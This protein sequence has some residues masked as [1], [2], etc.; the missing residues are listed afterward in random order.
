MRRDRDDPRQSRGTLPGLDPRRLVRLMEESITACELDLSGLVVLT[1]A[2]TGPYMV[3]PILAAMAGATRVHALTRTTRYGSAEEVEAQTLAVA[4]LAGVAQRIDVTTH[5]TEEIVASADIVTNSGHVRPIDASM[6]GW[7]KTAAVI[8]L[9]YEAWELRPGDLDLAACH[10]RGILV[11]GTNER[12]PAVDVF[13]YLGVMAIKLLLDAGV[14]VY[15]SMIL[16]LCDNPFA[17]FIVR[18]LEGAG[19]RVTLQSALSEDDRGNFDAVVVAIQP[20]AEA[21]LGAQAL[22]VLSR[23]PGV[24]VAQFWGD[25]DRGALEGAGIPFWPSTPPDPGH[26]GVLPSQ[27]GP[28]PIVRLQAGGL[29]V[30]Q[31]LTR[32]RSA[33]DT[34]GFEEGGF[35]QL[36]PPGSS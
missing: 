21:V 35:V 11:A 18:G 32:S 6:I 9:M 16:L 10:E 28:E 19:A 2:A 7:M 5:K 25:I 23:W 34:D 13:G 12:H 24:V 33:V 29:K 1:E 30:G 8:P 36:V 31:L 3:T 20:G 22:P 4:S 17:P 14:A 15:D 26:M 27:V